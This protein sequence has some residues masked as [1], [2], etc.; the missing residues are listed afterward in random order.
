MPELYDGNYVQADLDNL[1]ASLE[2]SSDADLIDAFLTQLAESEDAL[3]KLVKRSSEFDDP[4]FNCKAVNCFLYDGYNICRIRPLGSRLSN[5]RILYGYDNVH[6]DFYILAVTIKRP[7]LLPI[8]ATQNLYYD[9]EPNHPIS[10]RVKSE[11]DS[12]KLPR[13]SS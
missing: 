12:L 7:K 11:Y 5:Y 8:N 3:W 10:V 1:R 9:Y 4:F 13:L 2:T 6:D